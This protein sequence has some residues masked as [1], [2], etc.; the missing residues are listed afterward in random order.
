[1]HHGPALARL[2]YGEYRLSRH[3]ELDVTKKTFVAP[4]LT[5]ES[6]LTAA[7]VLSAGAPL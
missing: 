2:Q 5:S 1:L 4:V 6:T 7:V 3:K